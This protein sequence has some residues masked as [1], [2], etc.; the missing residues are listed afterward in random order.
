MPSHIAINRIGNGLYGNGVNNHVVIPHKTVFDM[1]STDSKSFIITLLP[2]T[3]LAS[4]AFTVPFSKLQTITGAWKGWLI[5]LYANGQIA[6][7]LIS[8]ALTPAIGA[9]FAT[10]PGAVPIGQISQVAI[11]KVGLNP[12]NWSIYVNGVSI[13]RSSTIVQL[14]NMI[15][16][17][18]TTTTTAVNVFRRDPNVVSSGTDLYK[19]Y[20]YDLKWFGGGNLTA[21]EIKFMAKNDGKIIP[22]TALSKLT[23][24]WKFDQKSLTP[25][26]SESGTNNGT[27]SGFI[28]ALGA[29][30]QWVDKRQKPILV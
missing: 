17:S 3:P 25:L 21:D 12:A 15:A 26:I 16:S 22:G 14:S 13:P 2:L 11:N 10:D 18:V 8:D 29:S 4:S 1:S 20:I 27:M 5:Y 28:T 19:G 9:T 24:W 23:D 6:F 30:N 7:S